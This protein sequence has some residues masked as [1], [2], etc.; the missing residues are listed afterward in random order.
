MLRLKDGDRVR[1]GSLVCIYE[2]KRMPDLG[3]VC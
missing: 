1:L 3:A 2:T